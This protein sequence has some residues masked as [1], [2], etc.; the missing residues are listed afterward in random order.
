MQ[1]SLHSHDTDLFAP[2]RLDEPRAKKKRSVG[3][4]K[5]AK[6][7]KPIEKETNIQLPHDAAAHVSAHVND[8]IAMKHNAIASAL[9]CA[10]RGA[11]GEHA[12]ANQHLEHLAKLFTSQP[13]DTLSTAAARARFGQC[14]EISV[15]SRKWEEQFLHEPTGCERPCVNFACG[16]CFAGSLQTGELSDLNLTL[17]EFYVPAE[18][19]KIKAAG[20]EWPKEAKPCLLCLRVEIYSRFIETRC[21]AL[22]CT[23]SINY[24]P[25]GNIVGEAGEYTADTCFLSR[26]DRYEGVL[27]PVVVPTV[28]DYGIMLVNGSRHLKQKLPYPEDANASFFF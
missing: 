19:E 17:C 3:K 16:C 23:E 24:A 14:H 1:M 22:S 27:H 5:S 13:H 2:R 15:I 10:P 21:N 20:W 11:P 4:S 25:I 18:Y 7:R 6:R 8:P 9:G 28:F 12:S 26:P